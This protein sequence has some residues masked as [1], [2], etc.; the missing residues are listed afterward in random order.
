MAKCNMGILGE[1]TLDDVKA[2]NAEVVVWGIGST[3]PHGPVLP[4]GTDYWQVDAVVRR[5]T[6]A[7]NAKGARAMMYP[8]MPIS[9]NANFQAWPFACR[10][11]P[12]TF[13]QLILDVI[14]ALEQDGIRKIVIRNGHGGNTDIINAAL[15]AHAHSHRPGQGA[16]VCQTQGSAPEGAVKHF[17][18]H[19]GES[20]VSMMLHLKRDLVREDKIG[21]Y[22]LGELAIDALDDPSVSFVKPWHLDVP[23]SCAGDQREASVQKGEA[24]INHSA[25]KLAELLCQLSA[26]EFNENFPYKS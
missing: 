24:I 6:I 7:A 23:A 17:S 8:T 19:G 11:A 12:Q 14:K 13:M 22:P 21:N 26:A 25:E 9:C 5:A 4:Y 1:M 16:F 18:Y 2:F 3:E 15:R 10:M 20:E